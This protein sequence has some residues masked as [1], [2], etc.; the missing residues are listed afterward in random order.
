M[1]Y[2]LLQIDEYCN[3]I[4]TAH[5]LKRSTVFAPN[6]SVLGLEYSDLV[7]DKRLELIVKVCRGSLEVTDY[8]GRQLV[9][10]ESSS[11]V[12]SSASVH[13]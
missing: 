4:Q 1:I 7:E 8:Y 12:I 6:L 13:I 2:Y 3:H 5:S 9:P 11:L 10:D